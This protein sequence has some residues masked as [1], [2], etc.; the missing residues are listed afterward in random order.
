MNEKI[1]WGI[2]GSGRM[3]GVFAAALS[4][5]P[6]A[7]LY[8]VASRSPEK[9]RAF[10]EQHTVEKVYGSY[11]EMLA[12]P[13]VD[14][15]YIATPIGQHYANILQCLHAGKHVL[16]EKCL[17]V[18]GR[19]AR[20]VIALAREKKLFLMEAMWTKCQPVFRKIMEWIQTGKIGEVQ[21]VDIR[22]YTAAGKGH[23]LY[24][25]EIAGGAFLDLGFYPVSYACAVLGD[26]PEHVINHTIIGERGVDY[27]DSIVLEYPDGKFAHLS[28]GLGAEKMVSLYI[29][30]SKGRLTMQEEYFFQAQKA[31]IVDFD[32]NVIDSCEGKFIENGYEFEAQEVMDCLKNHQIESKLVPLDSSLAVMDILDSCR[33]SAGYHFDFE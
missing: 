11:D 13:A 21:A 16:C 30:G 1:R 31:R 17:T 5:L 20:E 18:N 9:G 15:V 25:K 22:F 33:D 3:A 32:N 14:V 27:L 8:A 12:D 19:Q 7:K 2:M 29:L 10:A 4:V 24:R 6:E 28:C 26:D 23:R